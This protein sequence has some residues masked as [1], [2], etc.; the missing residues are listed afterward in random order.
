MTVLV[1]VALSS[2]CAVPV[3]PGWRR[4][5]V[6]LPPSAFARLADSGGQGR[7]V[8][9]DL[10][11][12]GGAARA[13]GGPGRRAGGAGDGPAV[14]GGRSAPADALALFRRHIAG[15]RRGGSDGDGVGGVG[16]LLHL[17]A[18]AGAMR[19]GVAGVAVVVR[20]AYGGAG[21]ARFVRFGPVGA[22]RFRGLSLPVPVENDPTIRGA[23]PTRRCG[24]H[25]AEAHR[26][27]RRLD[28]RRT[29]E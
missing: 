16:H 27:Q 18:G 2:L 11:G 14:F 24:S 19:G 21:I 12:A 29:G 13:A 6:A 5:P 15:L 1:V 26:R 9:A 22:G 23:E 8:S 17:R 7:G 4:R 10:D 3:R 28:N 25:C 20:A